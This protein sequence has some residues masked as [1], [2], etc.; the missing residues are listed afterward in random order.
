MEDKLSKRK[1][2]RLD[3]Y[4][5]GSCGAYFIT[6]CTIE[7]RNFFWNN[8]G[9]T[10]LCPQDIELSECGKIVDEAI[11]NISIIYPSVTVIQYVIMPDHVHLLLMINADENGRPMVAP[12]IPRVMKQLKGYVTKR[13]G[14]SVWQKLY[15]DHV[16]RNRNDF[17]ECAKY[18]HENPT[19][20]QY[21]RSKK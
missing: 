14:F 3:N 9:A 10:T 12:T 7:R 18:I 20:W 1:N 6:I 16:V 13:I 2:I 15:F 11:N 17:E 5:Y 8:V 19:R 4:D 21:R